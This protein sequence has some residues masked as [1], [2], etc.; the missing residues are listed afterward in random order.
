MIRESLIFATK[1]SDNDDLWRERVKIEV[2]CVDKMINKLDKEKDARLIEF[3]RLPDTAFNLSSC[4]MLALD[5]A[6]A[7]KKH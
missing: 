3:L 5:Y 4:R 6:R 2:G 7:K 1:T